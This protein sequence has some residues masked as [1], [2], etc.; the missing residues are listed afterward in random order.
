MKIEI[1]KIPIFCLTCEYDET[2]IKRSAI[3]S[4]FSTMN[5]GSGPEFVHPILITNGQRTPKNKS[6][7]SGFIRMI[8]TCIREKREKLQSGSVDSKKPTKKVVKK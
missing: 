8:E 7:A 5:N 4:E 3:K 6:G 2:S 1:K